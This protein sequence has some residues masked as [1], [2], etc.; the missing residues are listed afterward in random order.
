M[1]KRF[2]QVTE[3]LLIDSSMVTRH[4]ESIDKLTTPGSYEVIAQG[5]SMTLI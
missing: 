5:S 2:G 4:S 3:G 1:Q